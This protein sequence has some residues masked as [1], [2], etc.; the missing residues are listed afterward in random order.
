MKVREL[1]FKLAEAEE[2]GA[3]ADE[4]S[5]R[6]VAGI[7]ERY[8]QRGDEPVDDLLNAADLQSEIDGLPE[9]PLGPR[10]PEPD[11]VQLE[12]NLTSAISAL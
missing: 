9:V 11:V 10:E 8:I 5:T 6:R 2:V 3:P 12:K 4:T 7:V 1:K